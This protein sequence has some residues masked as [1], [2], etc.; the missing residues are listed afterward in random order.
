MACSMEYVMAIET[1][2]G[3]TVLSVLALHGLQFWGFDRP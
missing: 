3:S 2:K 1:K